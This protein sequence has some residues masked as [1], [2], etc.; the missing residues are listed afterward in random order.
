MTTLDIINY[1][2][3]IIPHSNYIF[4]GFTKNDY[5][6]VLEKNFE[7]FI[8]ISDGKYSSYVDNKNNLS[9]NYKSFLEYNL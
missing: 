5:M 2:L 8:V 4:Y 3:K 6:Y 9:F 7:K 1:E